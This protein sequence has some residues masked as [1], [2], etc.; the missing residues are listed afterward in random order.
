[1]NKQSYMMIVLTLILVLVL[2]FLA[3]AFLLPILSDKTSSQTYCLNDQITEDMTLQEIS[4]LYRDNASVAIRVSA[5]DNE[6]SA[7]YTSQGSGICVA[8]TG[9]SS[10]YSKLDGIMVKEGSYIVTNYH[11]IDWVYDENYSNISIT[12]V[13]EDESEYQAS[14]LWSNRNFDVAILYSSEIELDFIRMADRSIYCSSED[15]L[16]IEEVFTIGTPL[17]MQYL[18]RVTFGNVASNNDLT[19]ATA[20]AYYYYFNRFS[21]LLESVSSE[22]SVPAN[23]VYYEVIYLNNLYED[24]I[25]LSLGITPG[26]SGGGLFDSKGNLVGLVTMSTSV[27]STNGNQMNG[28]VPIYPVMQALDRIISNNE[29]GTDYIIYTLEDLG[30]VGLDSNE[31][32]Y[33]SILHEE[34]LTI[35]ENIGLSNRYLFDGNYYNVLTY[36]SAFSFE[37][38]G[39]YILANNNSF[40]QSTA[41]TQDSIIKSISINGETFAV[42]DRNELLYRLITIMPE[43]QVVISYQY[44]SQMNEITIQF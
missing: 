6:L 9:Y 7:S 44:A 22:E 17:S 20:M 12:I 8:S 3:S 31:A 21:G 38:E 37:E 2:S 40:S 15:K 30:L 19:Q 42:S 39:V 34:Q 1:M 29:Y 5:Y 24:V 43:D 28:A 25:D 23:T 33:V 41:I 10:I 36:S 14:V 18:N 16:D 4:K 35:L 26:N 32:A 11:V 13:T 27:S